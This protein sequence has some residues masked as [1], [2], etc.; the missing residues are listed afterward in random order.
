M[1]A[2]TAVGVAAFCAVF[3]V[4]FYR[5]TYCCQ[6]ATYLM[7]PARFQ[8]DFQ[9]GVVLSANECAIRENS[10]LSVFGPRL[11][12]VGFVLRL[13]ANEP[14]LQACFGLFGCALHDGPIGLRNRSLVVSP[15]KAS[16]GLFL[17]H[18]IEACERLAGPCEKHYSARRAV[19]TMRHAEK[20]LARLVVLDFDIRLDGL[21]Q[22]CVARLVA[23]HD[24]VAGLIDSN[25]MVVFVEDFHHFII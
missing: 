14:V 4:A 13:I 22:R 9:Q 23:L 20:H 3:E 10:L 18:L 7:M 24:L 15:V 6:L 12:D 25:D 5:A 8:I 16:L 2:Y 21:A 1:Q 17:E 19:Q 11:G